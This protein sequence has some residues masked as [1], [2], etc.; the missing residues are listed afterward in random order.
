MPK[1]IYLNKFLNFLYLK[2]TIF[3]V[4]E[5]WRIRYILWQECKVFKTIFQYLWRVF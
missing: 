2:V 5:V 1:E 3:S 4:G